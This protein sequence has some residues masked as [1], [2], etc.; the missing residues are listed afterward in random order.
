MLVFQG[1]NF[2]VLAGALSRP[3]RGGMLAGS[4][5]VDMNHQSP[6]TDSVISVREDAAG[7]ESSARAGTEQ[8]PCSTSSSL[9]S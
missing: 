7:G 6:H 5:F 2:A 1:K 8:D 9:R 3:S 4:K